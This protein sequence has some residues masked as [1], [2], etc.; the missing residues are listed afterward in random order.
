MAKI[1][2]DNVHHVT[3]GFP[4]AKSPARLVAVLALI[5]RNHVQGMTI[6]ELAE[7]SG[8]DRSTARRLLMVLVKTGFAAKDELT[9]HY[10]LGVEA[11]LTGMAA[12]AKPP[13]FEIC[14]PAMNKIAARTGDTVFLV[15]RIGDFAHCL[16]V[17]MGRNPLY[18]HSLMTGQVRLL[19]Q[20]TASL[21][22]AAALP[23]SE[24]KEIYTR[25]CLDYEGVG[26]DQERLKNMVDHTRKMRYSESVNL[27]TS[28]AA[29]VGIAVGLKE[30]QMAAI[31]VAT[32]TLH[33]NSNHKEE[34]V[35][36]LKEEIK[37][38]GMFPYFKTS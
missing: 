12:I 17:V 26:L 13:T 38:S 6:R 24:L 29:G 5:S 30:N 14:R 34:I 33:M 32:N 22:L 8:L 10:R 1:D 25:R 18:S 36:I 23:D 27:L 2:E 28:G 21:A 37:F 31:S 16:H 20:G 4:G 11:M 35:R 3:W 9:G 19:G 7:R 15:I